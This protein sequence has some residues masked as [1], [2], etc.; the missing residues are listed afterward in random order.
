M[1]WSIVLVGVLLF[2]L[3]R[4]SFPDG[5]QS[6]DVRRLRIVDDQGRPLIELSVE[7]NEGASTASLVMRDTRNRVRASLVSSDMGSQLSIFGGQENPSIA[8]FAFTD[9]D[10]ASLHIVD[11]AGRKRVVLSQSDG[12]PR[13]FLGGGRGGEDADAGASLGT[14]ADHVE[15]RLWQEKDAITATVGAKEGPTVVLADDDKEEWRAR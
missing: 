7:S 13:L 2:L 8:L 15:L 10:L 6:L 11:R 9:N 4:Q 1:K 5:R 12:S 14:I 3:S